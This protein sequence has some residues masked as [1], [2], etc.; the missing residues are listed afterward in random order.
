[1]PDGPPPGPF[2]TLSGVTATDEQLRPALEFAFA[3]AVA[4]T[5]L[6]PAI[7]PP[8]ALRP[9]LKFQKL[10]AGALVVVRK[11]IDTDEEFRGRV[12]AI[13]TED[14]TGEAGLVWLQREEGW[15]RR[16]DDLLPDE[17]T[18]TTGGEAGGAGRAERRRQAAEAATSRAHREIATLRTELHHERARRTEALRQLGVLREEADALRTERDALAV[19]CEALA[20]R[21]RET[22]GQLDLLRAG[23]EP[24]EARIA[25]LEGLLDAALAGRTAAAEE[26]ELSRRAERTS[27]ATSPAVGAAADALQAAAAALRQLA[28]ALEITGQ[29]VAPPVP[30]VSPPEVPRRVRRPKRV[31]LSIP[32]GLFDD[33]A[34]AAAHLLAQ[35]DVVLLVDGYNV[36]KLGWPALSLEQQREALLD[37]IEAHVR[38]SALNVEVV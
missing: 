32:G 29:A 38:R 10:P 3:V 2:A 24:L 5:R 35:P 34:A 7:A 21:G 15:E 14:Q 26:A 8:A 17:D 1:M 11:A 36:A 33:S 37:A 18:E 12:V 30:Q 20:G 27:A 25:E 22:A 28:A 9:Y 23:R 19:D 31:P 13:A 16:L 4:G 6:R